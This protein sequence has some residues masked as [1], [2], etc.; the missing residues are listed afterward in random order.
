MTASASVPNPLRFSTHY[1]WGKAHLPIWKVSKQRVNINTF[2]MLED[3]SHKI[4]SSDASFRAPRYMYQWK[5][6]TNLW[7]FETLTEAYISY[8]PACTQKCSS[9]LTDMIENFSNGSSSNFI[10][11]ILQFHKAG[12][13][14]AVHKNPKSKI[15]SLEKKWQLTFFLFGSPNGVATCLT[16]RIRFHSLA[17]TLFQLV[18]S[19]KYNL[20]VCKIQATKLVPDLTNI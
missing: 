1:V 16:W 9:L 17:S 12:I 2:R 6:S 18:D 5:H 3:N 20:S 10:L 7:G 13:Y 15:L 8:P 11:L 4:S 14:M 19:K